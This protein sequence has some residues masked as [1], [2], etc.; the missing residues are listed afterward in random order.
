MSLKQLNNRD[1]E[2]TAYT[3]ARQMGRGRVLGGWGGSHRLLPSVSW[4]QSLKTYPCKGSKL[5]LDIGG[6]TRRHTAGHAQPHLPLHTSTS[7]LSVPRPSQLS[8]PRP[9]AR[10]LPDPGY[11]YLPLH[12]G[13]ICCTRATM[14]TAPPPKT[15]GVLYN[16]AGVRP[17][18]EPH[19]YR[20][21][22]LLFLKL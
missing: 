16:T 9:P 11:K 2:T 6:N 12:P 3:A 5:P 13:G 17:S 15:Q 8:C 4:S 1:Q 10:S 19:P 22:H 14:A 21:P 7:G 20:P 18:Q